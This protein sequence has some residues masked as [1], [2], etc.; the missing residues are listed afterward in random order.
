MT[1]PVVFEFEN[2]RRRMEETAADTVLKDSIGKIVKSKVRFGLFVFD[3]GLV[4]VR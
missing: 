4:G 2:F 3:T 1:R